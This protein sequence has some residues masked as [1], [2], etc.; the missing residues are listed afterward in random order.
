MLRFHHYY[1]VG[2]D[3]FSQFGAAENFHHYDN[4]IKAKQITEFDDLLA[5]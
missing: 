1:C 2:Y 4:I 3:L 5:S